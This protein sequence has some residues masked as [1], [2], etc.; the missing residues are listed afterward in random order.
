[1][2]P[3]NFSGHVI[4]IKFNEI[5][6]QK[7]E[8]IILKRNMPNFALH[9]VSNCIFKV[10]NR[11]TRTKCEICSKLTIKT[12]ERRYWRRSGVFIVNCE[13]VS[14]L[15]NFVNSIVNFEL[16]NVHW[17]IENKYKSYWNSECKHYYV[18]HP[19]SSGKQLILTF[20]HDLILGKLQY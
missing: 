1:M 5:N 8:K 18:R 16:V 19:L 20:I 2:L 14:H 17:V 12:P 4:N 10:N 11:D 15:V 13:H 3:C 6:W 7:N 9:P